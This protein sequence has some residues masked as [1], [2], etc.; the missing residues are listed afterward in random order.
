MSSGSGDIIIKGGS[1]EVNFDDDLYPRD[2]QDPIIHRNGG[3]RITRVLI[4][5]DISFDS[6]ER[7]G[8]LIC[9]IKATTA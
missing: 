7:P 9:E 5:G 2:P 6:G 1:V 3:R 4:T 8:G